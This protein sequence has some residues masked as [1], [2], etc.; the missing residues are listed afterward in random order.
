LDHIESFFLI[1]PKL[2]QSKYNFIHLQT[3][4]LSILKIGAFPSF[5]V[6]QEIGGNIPRI[7]TIGCGANRRMAKTKTGK[8]TKWIIG[9]EEEIAGFASFTMFSLNIWFARTTAIRGGTLL[10]F[11]CSIRVTIAFSEQ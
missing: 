6:G 5:D 2:I 8:T 7:K 11:K 1:I 10:T 9:G 4:C 3:F